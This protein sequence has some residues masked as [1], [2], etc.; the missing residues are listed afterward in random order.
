MEEG[1]AGDGQISE[2]GS[3]VVPDVL[4]WSGTSEKSGDAL[5]VVTE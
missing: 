2:A 5:H 1:V 3:P 4:Q